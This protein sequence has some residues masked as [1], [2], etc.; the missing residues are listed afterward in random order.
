VDEDSLKNKDVTIRDRDTTIQIRVKT[1]ELH[2]TLK[3][4]INN[5]IPFSRAGKVV[6][7]RVKE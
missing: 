3:K 1:K 5:E 6:E 2:E 7:T 4:L